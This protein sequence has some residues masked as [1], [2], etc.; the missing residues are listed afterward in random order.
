M[1]HTIKLIVNGKPHEIE[2]ESRRL[3]VEVLREDLGLTGTKRGCESS[4]CGACT[5]LLD[6]LSV[7]A[8]SMLAIQADGRQVTTI[9]GIGS[10]DQLHP[11]QQ[12]FLD[13]Q[14]Y[15]CGYCTPGMVMSAVALLDENPNPTADDIQFGMAGNLCRCT[16][17]VKIVRSVQEAAKANKA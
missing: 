8:C 6:G 4:T 12:A 3:L 17:Y 10:K 9:E 13:H 2:V 11:V 16:G 15:Q 14:G 7:H 5:V 1:K